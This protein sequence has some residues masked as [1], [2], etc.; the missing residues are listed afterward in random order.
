MAKTITA[1]SSQSCRKKPAVS[2]VIPPKFLTA[3][4]KYQQKT[5]R[6]EAT[7][8]IPKNLP[9]KIAKKEAENRQKRHQ[10]AVNF[11]WLALENVWIRP[12]FFAIGKVA[13]A[14]ALKILEIKKTE[15][16]TSRFLKSI[17]AKIS[18]EKTKNERM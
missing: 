14:K 18:R 13:T 5:E 6:L 15:S 11:L 2:P 3:I 7:S 4:T 16:K 1:E 10:T 8:A 17:F 12:L 9:K